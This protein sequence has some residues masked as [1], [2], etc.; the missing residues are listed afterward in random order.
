MQLPLQQI[1]ILITRPRHQAQTLCEKIAA[2]GGQPLLF[3]TI[4]II[5]AADQAQ[6]QAQITQLPCYDL[7]IFI[8]PN[9]VW[10]ATPLIRAHWPNWPTTVKLAAIGNSTALALQ[11]NHWPVDI[12]PQ[13]QFNSEALLDLAALQNIHNKKIILF[14]GNDGRTLLADTLRARGAILSEA[15]VYQRTLPNTTLAMALSP[16]QKDAIKI[17]LAT[18]QAGLENLCTLVGDDSRQW[19][20]NMPLL[21]ISERLAHL[22]TQL[23]FVHTPIVAANAGDEAIVK[24][25]THLN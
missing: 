22:A 10:H 7:A 9:A 8:S 25:L 21:V 23:G 19:L 14:R 4:E 3:P 15:I 16:A 17:I 18:S 13:T 11:H 2:L 24:A 5:P 1:G 6:L 20:Q 12:Y